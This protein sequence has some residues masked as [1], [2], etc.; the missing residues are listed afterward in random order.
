MQELTPPRKL[1]LTALVW[2]LIR[3]AGLAYLGIAA[4]FFRDWK[5][6][7][8]ILTIPTVVTVTWFWRIPE[9]PK[10]YLANDKR[11]QVL[12]TSRR[13]AR[14]NRDKAFMEEFNIADEDLFKPALKGNSSLTKLENLFKGKP[15][16]EDML[17]VPL[18]DEKESLSEDKQPESRKATMKDL[19]QNRILLRHL[20]VMLIINF[21][22]TIAYYVILLYIP[23]LPGGRHLNFI[24]G[25]AIEVVACISTYFILSS[26]LGRRSSMILFQYLNTAF[27]V[28][29]GALFF[30]SYTGTW[31]PYFTAIIALVGKGVTSAA[32]IG[33]KV[34]GAE[35]FPTAVRATAMGLCGFASRGGSLIA[36]QVILVVSKNF[37][38]LKSR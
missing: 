32:I 12:R 19:F 27:C 23:N 2:E 15:S 30:V 6:L 37:S 16:S 18:N 13:I 28:A 31:L 33:M 24:M 20:S 38:G 1:T 22:T 29:F 4:Y 34:H 26:S 8:L 3:T 17:K 35:L 5:D 11:V 7:Q 14:K 36:P 9:S 21:S 10:W 25:T